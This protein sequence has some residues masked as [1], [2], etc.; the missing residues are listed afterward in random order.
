LMMFYHKLFVTE[1]YYNNKKEN[2]SRSL[3]GNATLCSV[4]LQVAS[5]TAARLLDSRLGVD[6]PASVWSTA[7]ARSI[8]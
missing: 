2:G 7:N 8:G 4:A 1:T 6:A 3:L 5:I